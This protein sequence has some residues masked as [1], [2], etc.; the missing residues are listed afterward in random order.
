MGQGRQAG[1][2]QGGDQEARGDADGLRHIVVFDLLALGVDPVAL[3][4]DRDQPGRGLKEGLVGVGA[5]RRQGLKP[6]LS[7]SSGVEFPLLGLGRG[8]QFGAQ[9]ARPDQDKPPG[10]LVGSAGRRGGRCDAALDNLARH[11]AIAEI[12]DRVPATQARQGGVGPCQ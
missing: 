1:L 8:A 3:A 7:G 11:R 5:Q 10:L 9:A 4:E 2:V 6:G 12:A